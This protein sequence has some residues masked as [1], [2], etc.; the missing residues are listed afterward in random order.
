MVHNCLGLRHFYRGSFAE[1]KEHLDKAMELFDPAK[2]RE[3]TAVYGGCAGFYGH[4]VTTWILL[5]TGKMDQAVEH[6]AKVLALAE[7]MDEP[8]TL[9]TTWAFEMQLAFQRREPD[10][11]QAA[12]EKLQELCHQFGFPWLLATGEIGLGW[13]MAK[14]G[15]AKEA[16]ARMRKALMEGW[17]AAGARFLFPHYTAFLVEVLLDHDRVADGLSAVEEGLAVSRT[18]VEQ[19][20]E[21]ELERLRGELLHRAGNP[22]EEIETIFRDALDTTRDRGAKLLEIRLATSLAR[23]LKEEDRS[24][25]AVELLKPVVEGFTEGRDTPNYTNAAELLGELQ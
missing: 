25:E 23:L 14:R 15:E 24:D 18:S 16:I 9:T 20:Y 6:E 3:N 13:A 11:V 8:Y 21:P 2:H 19:F 17:R 5:L 22:A 4:M 7:E 1:A 12:A 10:R